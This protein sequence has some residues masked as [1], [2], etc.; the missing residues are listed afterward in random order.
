[1]AA[2]ARQ[3]R[4]LHP[5]QKKI[6][7]GS[8][9]LFLGAFLPWFWTNVGNISAIGFSFDRNAPVLTLAGQPGLWVWMASCMALAAALAPWRALSI[10]AGG[11]AALVGF[12][13]PAYYLVR[14]LSG[15]WFFAQADWLPGPGLV[16]AAGTAIMSAIG[17]WELS[18]LVEEP[19]GGP[20]LG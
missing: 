13:L 8:I 6:L 11:I 2:P 15:S 5:G 14:A 16:L 17:I 3:R 18:R 10:A 1:M 4:R 20:R 9:A 7:F 12:G 19:L